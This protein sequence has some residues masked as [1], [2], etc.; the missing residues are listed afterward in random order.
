MQ[1]DEQLLGQIRQTVASG[2]YERLAPTRRERKSLADSIEKAHADGQLPLLLE[3]ASAWPDTGLLLPTRERTEELLEQLAILDLTGLSVWVEPRFHAGDLRW[4]G[5]PMPMPLLCKDWVVDSRQIV[6]G[7]AV[8]LSR[9][10]LEFAGADEHAL[11]EAA[12]EQDIEVVMEVRTAEQLGHAKATEAD[13][14]AINNHGPNGGAPG[15]NTT[16]QMLASHKTGRPVISTYGIA[17]AAQVR[18]LLV[19]GASAVELSARQAREDNILDTV[20]ALRRAVLG[21]DPAAT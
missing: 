5:R 15:I 17:D 3:V 21:K 1:L 4:L 13:I 12:H 11:I 10:L 18:A 20:R 16:L 2:Y 14:I 6:G 9:P 19:A 7:D 8:M